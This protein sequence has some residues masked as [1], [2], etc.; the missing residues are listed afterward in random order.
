MDKHFAHHFANEWVA[1]WNSH[2]MD[3]IMSHYADDFEM[4]SPVIIQVTGEQSGR[5]QGKNAVRAYWEKAL[6]LIPTL[7]FELMGYYVG[8]NSL[9]IH[10][11]GHRGLSAETFIFN[12]E[13]KVAIAF[14]HYQAS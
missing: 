13:G 8:V 7:H 6:Q 9:V 12:N 14:A 3:R 10:Y 2:D 11:K 1:A 5:L 4:H